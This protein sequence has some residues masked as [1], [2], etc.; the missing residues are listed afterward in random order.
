MII[1]SKNKGDWSELYV[2]LYLLGRRK[3]YTADEQ[4]NRMNQ[5]PIRKRKGSQRKETI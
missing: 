3:L 2:L 5:V 4:L 1:G